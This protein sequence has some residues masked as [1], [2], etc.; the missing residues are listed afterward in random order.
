M[1]KYSMPR[2]CVSRMRST[3]SRT[4]SRSGRRSSQ[5]ELTKTG[6]VCAGRGIGRRSSVEQDEGRGVWESS[7]VGLDAESCGVVAH[8]LPSG[9]DECVEALLRHVEL[10]RPVA[11]RGQTTDLALVHRDLG[12]VLRAGH[13][14]HE[15]TD[16]LDGAKVAD[17]VR[18]LGRLRGPGYGEVLVDEQAEAAGGG[19]VCVAPAV[20]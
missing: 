6:T 1:P 7:A 2:N 12:L 3:A 15:A 13:R 4:A 18:R 5:V 10:G 20:L 8:R 16:A 17:L 19:R 9:L 11:H 14:V